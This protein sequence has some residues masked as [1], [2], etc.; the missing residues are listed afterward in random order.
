MKALVIACGLMGSGKSSV[1]RALAEVLAADVVSSDVV[2]KE[3]TDVDLDE[4]R[5]VAFDKGIYSGDTTRLVYEH[6]CERAATW[7]KSGQPIVLDACFGKRWQRDLARTTA[8][9]YGAPF[10][11]VEVTCP[12]SELKRRLASR[13]ADGTDVSD[14]R[15]EIFEEHRRKFEAIEE[16]AAPEHLVVDGRDPPKENARSALV[17]LRKRTSR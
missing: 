17:D 16:L 2:R 6:M 10:L 4:H 14:G 15:L 7:L 12:L 5:Y 13:E 1:A 9:R 3:L 8:L 11:C